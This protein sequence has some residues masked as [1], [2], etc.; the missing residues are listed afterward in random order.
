MKIAAARIVFIVIFTPS[1]TL[2]IDIPSRLLDCQIIFVFMFLFS[3]FSECISLR[4]IALKMTSG[5]IV[6]ENAPTAA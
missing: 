2:K 4:K 6:A 3:S 5:L 1:L